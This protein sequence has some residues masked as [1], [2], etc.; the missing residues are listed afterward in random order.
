[1]RE[2]D[3]R[4]Q[5]PE[6][7][8]TEIIELP[9]VEGGSENVVVDPGLEEEARFE[10]LRAA[11]AQ[12]EKTRPAGIEAARRRAAAAE[13]SRKE[14]GDARKKELFGY[15][16]AEGPLR[17]ALLA[18]LGENFMSRQKCVA[19]LRIARAQDEAGRELDAETLNILR[20]LERVRGKTSGVDFGA[21][22]GADVLFIPVEVTI[23]KEVFGHPLTF[24]EKL[25]GRF[26]PAI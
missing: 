4:G 1:M 5:P 22:A 10:A 17:R 15:L 12:E 24:K 2:T 13:P 16:E 9:R 8:R 25:K 20:F 23:S 14:G 26:T 7:A 3:G 21:A 19:D 18:R 6:E 11:K